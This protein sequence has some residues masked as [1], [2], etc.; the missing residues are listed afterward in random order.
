VVGGRRKR[1]PG[2]PYRK[3][4]NADC[5]AGLFLS[6]SINN[7][8]ITQEAG[9]AEAMYGWLYETGTSSSLEPGSH[10]TGDQRIAAFR[11]G[12]SNGTQ[13]CRENY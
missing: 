8:T 12:A 7:G 5:L 6:A 2:P 11:E 3:E 9:D 10:G 1:C 4:R 13:Y